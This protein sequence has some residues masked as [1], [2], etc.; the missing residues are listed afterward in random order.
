[1]ARS[2]GST[3]PIPE[4]PWAEWWAEF[5]R[6]YRA[7]R[8]DAAHVTV[9]G[10][11]R[12]GKS[13]LAMEIALLRPYVGVLA[14]KPRDEHMRSMLKAQGFRKVAA[15]PEGGSGIRRAVI[16]PSNRGIR[17][18]AAQRAAFA[19][20]FEHAYRIGIWHLLVDEAHYMAQTLRLA[21]HIRGAYQMGRSNGHGIILAAQRPAWLPRDIY[22][23]A[24]HLM[25]FGT[26][27]SADLKS[28]SGMNGVND[29][30][31]RNTVAE[32]GRG[33]R[34]L[35]VDTV[36]GTLQITRLEQTHRK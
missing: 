27:D 6:N 35:H 12:S 26:N 3:E 29:V 1:M 15:L 31:V 4:V 16:W 7:T 25:I 9:I 20:A 34:F 32:L 28:I 2:T 23:S 10:P 36:R 14:A 33:H 18:H 30:V 19:D 22:S 21:D 5:R 8:D 24:E 13:T 11:T 17:D